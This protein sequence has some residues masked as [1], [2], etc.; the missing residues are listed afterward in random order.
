MSVYIPAADTPEPAL[1]MARCT[2]GGF[3][4]DS[5]DRTAK[6][7][8]DCTACGLPFLPMLIVVNGGRK[9]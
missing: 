6:A 9:P 3:A 2:C 1:L 8:W 4:Y 5:H 7:V